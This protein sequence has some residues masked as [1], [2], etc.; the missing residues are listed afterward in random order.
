MLALIACV[1]LHKFFVLN[2]NASDIDNF[3]KEASQEK[4]NLEFHWNPGW[5]FDGIPSGIPPNSTGIKFRESRQKSGIPEI[6]SRW[7]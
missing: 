5:N 7:N 1:Y 6:L 4:I 2:S 3:W